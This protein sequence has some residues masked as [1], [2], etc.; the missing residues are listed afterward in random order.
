[1]RRCASAVLA[2]VYAVVTEP[3]VDVTLFH[4]NGNVSGKRL[5]CL[6]LLKLLYDVVV[7]FVFELGRTCAVKREDAL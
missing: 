3:H 1:M 7:A 2:P 5:G 6:L 4:G